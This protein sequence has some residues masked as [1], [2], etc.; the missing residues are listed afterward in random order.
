MAPVTRRHRDI[1][2]AIVDLVARGTEAVEEVPK[3]ALGHAPDDPLPRDEGRCRARDAGDLDDHVASPLAAEILERK[4]CRRSDFRVQVEGRHRGQAEDV[5]TD[6]DRREYPGTRHDVL[7]HAGERAAWQRDT[8]FFRGF[9][10]GGRD[11]VL[12]A[13]LAA[14][15]GKR[16]VARPGITLAVG[17]T[18]DEHRV[19]IGNQHQ[20]HRGPEQAGL[21]GYDRQSRTEAAREKAIGCQWEWEWERQPPPQQ[22]PAAGA[23]TCAGA[24]AAEA[25]GRAVRDISR[26]TAPLPQVQVTVAVPRTSRSKRLPQDVQW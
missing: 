24:P 23:G 11:E 26:S 18:N 5:R 17:A 22:P 15:A 4:P 25:A 19:G 8:D 20:C 12:V 16:H 7:E 10:D 14:A 6:G 13:R 2:G 3:D 21:I 9:P 1:G